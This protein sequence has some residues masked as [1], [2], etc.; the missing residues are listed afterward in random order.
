MDNKCALHIQNVTKCFG[1]IT[2]SNDINIKVPEKALYGII[3]P[4]GAGKT[5]LFNMITGVYAPSKG[6]IFYYG[7]SIV[8]KATYEIANMGIKRTFQN[9]RLFSDLTVFDNILTAC[10]NDI[11]YGLIDAIL[12]TKRCREQEKNI[13]QRCLNVLEQV[14]LEQ[15]ANYKAGN[16]P[17]GL[18]RRL[19]IARALVTSPKILLLDEPAAG[20]NEDESAHLTDFIRNLH[21][22]SKVTIIIIDHHM[23]VIMNL[24]SRISVVNF[25]MLL[26]EGTPEEIQNNPEVI[27]AYLGGD[28]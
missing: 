17:Y 27:E 10:Q 16:L 14:G 12:R 15:Y 20:M 4:N 5:T 28:E 9:I 3:G 22:D 18:Q 1:G 24:C 2:A 13:R 6:D 7:K 11:T 19:E 23:D 26:A 25:G 8:G 21:S